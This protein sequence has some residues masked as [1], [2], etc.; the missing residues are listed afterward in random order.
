MN[1]YQPY[2]D[3]AD[4]YVWAKR[5]LSSEPAVCHGAAAA[6]GQVILGGGTREHAIAAARQASVS[7][8][9]LAPEGGDVRRRTYAEW[10][11]WA[12]RELGGVREQQHDAAR[13]AMA[14]LDAGW[15]A[16]QAM[17]A[18]R[19]VYGADPP[20]P[21]PAAPPAY[22]H[23]VP[24]PWIPSAP[25]APAAPAAP[26]TFLR[27]LAAFLIDSFVILVFYF[28][29]SVVIGFGIGF[30]LGLQGQRHVE[31][32]QLNWLAVP[33]LIFTTL[34]AWAYSTLPLSS[35]WAATPG[36]RALG[37]AVVDE[38]GR[39]LSLGRANA[40]FFASWLSALICYAGF[41]VALFN[42]RRQALHDMIAG[43]LVVLRT[44]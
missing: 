23:P 39:R 18:A 4:W 40:R 34:F 15:G 28:A 10:F 42:G 12:R 44:A 3:Y 13:A 6:A 31:T 25:S 38:Q 19:T 27:R 43:T 17:A 33:I 21:V 14:A 2:E 35:G 9:H 36:K 41:L 7:G 22:Q 16:N 29:I 26:A 24:A 8:G 5:N 32:S 20:A 30:G 1:P 11:D 37:L